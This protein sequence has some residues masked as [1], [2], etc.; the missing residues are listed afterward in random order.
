MP[1]WLVGSALATQRTLRGVASFHLPISAANAAGLMVPIAAPVAHRLIEASFRRSAEAPR[2]LPAIHT[3]FRLSV[4]RRAGCADR[5][6]PDDPVSL[7]DGLS[8][9]AATAVLSPARL[10]Y[11]SAAIITSAGRSTAYR[12]FRL[13]ED[14]AVASSAVCVP[15]LDPRCTS[16]RPPAFVAAPYLLCGRVG[17][18][19]PANA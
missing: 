16:H 2:Q 5:H 6:A 4:V 11:G 15:I 19:S 3:C 12:T 17:H 7:V 1:Y 10:T 9:P 14:P 8:A 13:F 18:A